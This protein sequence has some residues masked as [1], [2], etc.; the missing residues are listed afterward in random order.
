MTEPTYTSTASP[1][2]LNPDITENVDTQCKDNL[3]SKSEHYDPIISDLQAEQEAYTTNCQETCDNCSSDELNKCFD[4]KINFTDL[5]CIEEKDEHKKREFLWQYLINIYNEHTGKLEKYYRVIEKN[6]EI[7]KAQKDD[8]IKVETV[9]TNLENVNSTK[10]RKIEISINDYNNTIYQLHFLKVSVVVLGVLVIIPLLKYMRFITPGLAVSVYFGSVLVLAVYGV[11]K[12]YYQNLNR[13]DNDFNKFNFSKPNNNEILRSRL[14]GKMSERSKM[15]C[16]AIKELE[17]NDY[18]KDSI[19]ISNNMMKKWKNET[20]SP[21]APSAT[22]A[23]APTAAA[24]NAATNVSNIMTS[25]LL[26]RDLVD[27]EKAKCSTDISVCNE[28]LLSEDRK[29]RME[30]IEKL[31]GA[32]KIWDDKMRLDKKYAENHGIYYPEQPPSEKRNY[33]AY[34]NMMKTR[35]PTTAAPNTQES[36]NNNGFGALAAMMS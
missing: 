23:A 20:C 35:K 16:Q 24:P 1:T 7:V 8:I 28:W 6:D 32:E 4:N 3:L 5:L 17:E 14:V 26:L 19:A 30:Q 13:D 2:S 18:D 12:L 21:V 34:W 9:L 10:K 27:M 22:T 33:M 31:G 29:I 15:R 36:E 11:Y 25:G